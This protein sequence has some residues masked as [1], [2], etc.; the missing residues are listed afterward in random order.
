MV[1]LGIGVRGICAGHARPAAGS[2]RFGRPLNSCE[3]ALRPEKAPERRASLGWDERNFLSL[4]WPRRLDWRLL[5]A[6]L[7]VL[8]YHD[9]TG[10][11]KCHSRPVTA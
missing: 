10:I 4:T 11:E 3:P 1:E 2:C 8:R 6:R 9:P 5:D 7:T